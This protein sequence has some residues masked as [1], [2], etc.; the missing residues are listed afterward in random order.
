[1]RAINASSL[2]FASFIQNSPTQDI[3]KN[4]LGGS[5]QDSP[6]A[7]S[8][9]PGFLEV[10][11]R[12]TSNHLTSELYGNGFWSGWGAPTN[13]TLD[14]A[15]GAVAVAGSPVHVFAISGHDLVSWTDSPV[16]NPNGW[17]LGGTY[18]FC[19]CLSAL[20]YGPT[21][22]AWTSNLMSGTNLALQASASASSENAGPASRPVKPSMESSMG[23]PTIRPENGPPSMEV[24][25]T[26]CN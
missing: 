1:M 12:D 5:I 9:L 13:F 4:D 6:S 22:V 20:L 16:G 11:T 10:F 24:Q 19:D 7:V 25:G 8:W 26:G 2:M 3:M 14:T 23:L 15:P 17:P 21:A 18:Y